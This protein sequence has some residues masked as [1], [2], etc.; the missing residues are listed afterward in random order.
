MYRVCLFI[1]IEN[2]IVYLKLTKKE[3]LSCNKYN[4]KILHF[5]LKT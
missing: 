3:I 5:I 2:N 4:I 1:F